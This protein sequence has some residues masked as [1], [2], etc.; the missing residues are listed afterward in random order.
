MARRK[1]EHKKLPETPVRTVIDSLTHDGRGVAH[2]DGKAVFIDAALP[3]EE[4]EF[5]YTDIRRD[6]AEGRVVNLLSKAEYRVD[7][8]CPHYDVCGGCSFQHVASSEQ[9]HI[10]EEL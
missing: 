4:L 1:R 3:D 9:I 7:A 10:K 5:V 2:V 8:E 6:F